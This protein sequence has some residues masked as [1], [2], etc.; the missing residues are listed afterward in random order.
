VR[1]SI[2]SAGRVALKVYDVSGRL[3]AA[4]VDRVL[5]P[6]SYVSRIPTGDLAAG[7]Y[8]YSLEAGGRKLSRRL[9]V[10]R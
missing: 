2:P 4:P 9:V 10:V 8:F 1:F 5:E 6:G 7:V 3:V